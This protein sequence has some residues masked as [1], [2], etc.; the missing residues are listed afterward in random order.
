MDNPENS[1]Y[2][3]I[4]SSLTLVLLELI[5]VYRERREKRRGTTKQRHRDHRNKTVIRQGRGG[6]DS[7]GLRD[8]LPPEED[9]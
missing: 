6:P 9:G 5:K 1:L 3:L 8:T 7:P 4:V 2:G